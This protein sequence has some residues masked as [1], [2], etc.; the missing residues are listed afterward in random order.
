MGIGYHWIMSHDF[1]DICQQL[2]TWYKRPAG[3]YLLDQEKALAEKLLEQVFGYHLLQI[4]VTR[5]QPL[6]NECGLNHR[7]YMGSSATGN[8]GLVSES[9]LLPLANDSIDAVILHHALDFAPDPHQL[10][11]EVQRVLSPQGRVVIIGF[12]PWSLSGAAS[13]LRGLAPGLLWRSSNR[14]SVHRVRDWLHLLGCE[15]ETVRHTYATPPRGRDG[16]ARILQKADQFFTRHNLFFGGVYAMR[17][18][19]FVATLTP[20]RRRVGAGVRGQ[21]IGLVVPRPVA[22]DG[23]GDA[24]A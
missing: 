18:Q 24:P 16:I 12:N 10:L 3:Q 20:T 6:V 1:I 9:S 4:G 7:I 23:D 11:R 14:L 13:R 5:D 15:V 8:V 19:K 21:L 2:E 17:A 22:R